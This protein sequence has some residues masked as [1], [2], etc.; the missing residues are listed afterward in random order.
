MPS[1]I[2]QVR[3]CTLCADK[4]PLAPKPI[5]QLHPAAKLLIAGQAPGRKAHDA[6]RAFA[7][8]SGMRLR[9]WLGL[10]D[11]QFYDPQ[12]VA[13]LPMGFCFPGS[14]KSGDLPPRPECAAR[15]REALLATL[16]NIQLTLVV[17][18][19]ALKWHKPQLDKKVT[20]AVRCSFDELLQ[21]DTSTRP[22]TVV[23]P[24]P[25]PRN[26]HWLRANPWFEQQMLPLL[27]ERIQLLM[28]NQQ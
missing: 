19:Y 23:L 5:L 17:G 6:G 26:H 12:L 3:N 8:Q 4:L 15:W 24:H 25:S 13:I 9:H 2:Q 28:P 11:A 16:G 10:T 22:V 7:D 1:L 20:A 18:Q 27:H 14:G 21:T